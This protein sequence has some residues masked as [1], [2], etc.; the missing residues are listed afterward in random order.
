MIDGGEDACQDNSSYRGQAYKMLLRTV[1]RKKCRTTYSSIQLLRIAS[2][3]S[4]SMSVARH[5]KKA[6]YCTVKA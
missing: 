3:L 4:V 2:Q 1:C 5:Q 6:S